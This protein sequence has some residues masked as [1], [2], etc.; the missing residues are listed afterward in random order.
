M[1][2]YF[3]LVSLRRKGLWAF[4]ILSF[5]FFVQCEKDD[6]CVDGDT[7]LLIIRFYDAANPTEFKQVTNLRVLGVGQATPV[8]TF[9]DRTSIDSIGIPLRVNQNST[10]FALIFDSADDNDVEAGNT[11]ILTFNYTTQE[12]FV[13]RACG[14]V[15]NYE[16][17]TEDLVADTDN[18]IQS[19]EIVSPLI[20][21]QDSAHVK[22]FH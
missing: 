17:L 4:G 22:I 16:E 2:Q 18:W 13:S 9:S 20:Q 5:L 1:T 3:N 11:D 12:V 6:I 21:T 19:I 14:F 15:A 7:P 10:G 8:N